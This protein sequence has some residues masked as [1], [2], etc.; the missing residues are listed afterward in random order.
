MTVKSKRT[1]VSMLIGILILVAY[2]FYMRTHMVEDLQSLAKIMLIF[3]GIGILSVI[4]IY[5]VFHIMFAIGTAAK[6]SINGRGDSDVERIVE[7]A[8]QED[9][10]DKLIDLKSAQY[11]SACVGVGF[12][13]ALGL[14]AAG[15]S[16]IICLHIL[17]GAFFGST[18]IQGVVTVLYYERGL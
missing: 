18:I 2:I 10:M 15:F 16:P 11:A 9:E 13:I 7:N 17:F 1:I 6:E 12:L 3:I 4:V 14:L 8:F 5:I